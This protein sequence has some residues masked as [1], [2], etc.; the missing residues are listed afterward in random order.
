MKISRE[1]S[2]KIKIFLDDYFPAW[3]RDSRAFLYLPFR[4]QFGKIS[5][6]YFN[7]R[8]TAYDMTEKEFTEAYKRASSTL[9]HD[10]TDLNDKCF[11]RIISDT[12]GPKVFEIACGRGDL[13]GELSKTFQVTSSDIVHNKQIDKYP[14]V[15][16]VLA[17]VEKLPFKDKSFDTVISTH[18]LEHTR[19]IYQ[20]VQELRRVCKKRLIVVLPKERPYKFGFNFHLHFFPYN[21]NIY[22]L[23]GKPKKS[24]LLNIDNDW[25]YVENY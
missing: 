1:L 8:P 24:E 11:K 22:A 18:T 5:E 12:I 6:L 13:S 3:V 15:K 10:G 16:F 7:F 17:N 21:F 9:V 23:F 14:K 4:A 25:Y 19:N 2:S 20:A